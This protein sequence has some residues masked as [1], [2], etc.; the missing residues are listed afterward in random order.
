[1]QSHGGVG[2]Q[3]VNLGENNLAHG[4]N[5]LKAHTVLACLPGCVLLIH[6]FE[7]PL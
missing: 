6:D 2:L 7:R 3:D 1:M 4:I 5:L